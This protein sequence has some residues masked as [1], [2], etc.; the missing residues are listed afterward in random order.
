MDHAVNT[1]LDLETFTFRDDDDALVTGQTTSDFTITL[2]ANGAVAAGVCA[3]TET[4]PG[5]Y[6]PRL[7]PPTTGSWTVMLEWVDDPTFAWSYA[8]QVVT[9]A[10]AD[11]LNAVPSAE[12]AP[13][14][15]AYILYALFRR[16]IEVIDG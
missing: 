3:V 13:G 9:A 11:P 5:R 14:T 6:T 7:T 2:V 12:S 15:V 4:A 1:P 8:F 10:Q 16:P